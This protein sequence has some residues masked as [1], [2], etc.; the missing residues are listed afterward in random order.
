MI[1]RFRFSAITLPLAL[2]F[3]GLFSAFCVSTFTAHAQESTWT[4]VEV[5][6]FGFF[7]SL[8]RTQGIT[9]D[10]QGNVWYSANQTMIRLRGGFTGS[11][12]ATNADPIPEELKRVGEN[13]VG[14]IDLV[15][16]FIFAPIEDGPKYQRPFV[17]VYTADTLELVK[18]MEIP[19]DW[20]PD[21][22]PW[23]TVDL[24][25]QLLITA[26][27]H[28][29]TRINLYNMRTGAAVKQIPMSMK[30]DSIQGG[31]YFNNHLYMTANDPDGGH[32]V[33]DMSLWTGEVHK[34]IHLNDDI[35]E[36]EGLTYLVDPKSPSENPSI[37]DIFVLGVAGSGLNKRM[38]LYHWK[39]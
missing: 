26:Q 27:Y 7:E 10:Q 23:L 6:R 29:T 36:V 5:H 20:L 37:S 4:E 17:G 11:T 19:R 22:I 14:D 30:L 34:I 15:G 25:H 13:H 16:N 35:S 24:Y 28:Q 9:N 31:K 12:K 18:L 33:Y 1:G 3:S 38:V 39:R 2:L 8:Q 21:G 32:A